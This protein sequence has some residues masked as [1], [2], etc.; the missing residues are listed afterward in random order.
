MIQLSELSTPM[1]E[2]ELV[3]FSKEDINSLKDAF[4]AFDANRDGEITIQ[5]L[6]QVMN[7]FLLIFKP[8]STLL[9][10]VSNSKDL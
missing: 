8:D 5:E 9:V 2:I 6:A 4:D 3:K 7:S 10:N 1:S